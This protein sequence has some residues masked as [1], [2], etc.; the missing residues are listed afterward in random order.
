LD[1]LCGKDGIGFDPADDFF[2]AT[3]IVA[4]HGISLGEFQPYGMASL[5]KASSRSKI[6]KKRQSNAANCKS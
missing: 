2:S 5:C 4:M 6:S 3:Y 1:L